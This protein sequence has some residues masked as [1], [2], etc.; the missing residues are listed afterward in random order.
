MVASLDL[1][2]FTTY[3]TGFALNASE[4][5]SRNTE[6]N[7]FFQNGTKDYFPRQEIISMTTGEDITAGD[8]V[9]V[10]SATIVK[11]DNTTAAGVTNFLGCAVETITSG[12][13]CRVA[14]NAIYGLTGLTAGSTYYLLTSGTVTSTRPDTFPK[15]IGYAISTSV[16][17]FSGTSEE[18]QTISTMTMSGL[19]TGGPTAGT[20]VS[21]QAFKFQ[22]NNLSRNNGDNV[23]GSFFMKNSGG[24]AAEFSRVRSEITNT[25]SGGSGKFVI[26]TLS[27]GSLND[28]LTIDEAG[29]ATLVGALNGVTISSGAVS[30]VSTL[31]QSGLNT[32]GPTTGTDTSFQ[33]LIIKTENT[34]RT[35][36][37]EVYASFEMKDSGGTLRESGRIVSIAE[38]VTSSMITTSMDFHIRRSSSLTNVFSIGTDSIKA[39]AAAA[40]T[41]DFNFGTS[42]TNFARIRYDAST[43]NLLLQVDVN[44]TPKGMVIEAT[45]GNV[46]VGLS[47]PDVL[48]DVNGALGILDGMTAPSTVSGK[49]FLYVDTSDGDLKVKFGDG[50]V[51]TLATDT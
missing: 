13:P 18:D 34:S 45:T 49:A 8:F 47:D 24:S 46:G 44:A 9:R 7:T 38:N 48:M 40:G 42:S 36:G 35:N 2:S 6:G 29:D 10:T 26:S 19:L 32:I 51:K 50:T 31:I 37:D 14:I 11:T 30:G 39:V 28:A 41:M 16:I 4:W 3:S 43:E 21:F 22:T 20:T 1:A 23:Y 33:G 15:A 17:I 5:N 12:N 27:G 25:T